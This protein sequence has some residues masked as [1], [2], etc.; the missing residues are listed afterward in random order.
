M[1]GTSFNNL[2]VW[3]LG[4]H[5]VWSMLCIFSLWKHCLITFLSGWIHD[6]YRCAQLMKKQP[7]SLS[8]AV[9]FNPVKSTGISST[10]ACLKALLK[11]LVRESGG[12]GWGCG[13][14]YV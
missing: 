2:N 10:L 3:F 7:L 4:D 1:L 9:I 12:W 6:V 13:L 8:G 14:G 5:F 11:P